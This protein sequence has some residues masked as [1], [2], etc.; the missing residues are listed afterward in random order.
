ME[1]AGLWSMEETGRHPA[2]DPTEACPHTAQ[3]GQA[4]SD[5][6]AETHVDV[7]RAQIVALMRR[8][9]TDRQIIKHH[10]LVEEELSPALL[11]TIREETGGVRAGMWIGGVGRMAPAFRF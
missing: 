2:R 6:D 9:Y 10:T 8:G 3:E 7:V 5:G 1:E 11:A 4:S